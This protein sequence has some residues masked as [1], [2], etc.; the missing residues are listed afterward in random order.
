M[1]ERS[2][3]GAVRETD[4]AIE[5]IEVHERP[6]SR[7]AFKQAFEV[8]LAY[9]RL[10]SGAT[11]EVMKR[12]I[13]DPS[14]NQLPDGLD[15]GRGQ[16]P[17]SLSSRLT[18]GL[19]SLVS[20]VGLRSGAMANHISEFPG[21]FSFRVPD[22]TSLRA[23]LASL[24]EQKEGERLERDLVKNFLTST[25]PTFHR[26]GLMLADDPFRYADLLDEFVSRSTNED[27]LALARARLAERRR[28]QMWT[29]FYR[30]N[31]G[32]AD[33]HVAEERQG[34]QSA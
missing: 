25:D 9:N 16:L 29:S 30:S 13:E 11:M 26:L 1:S 21:G 3:Q 28:L 6:P 24:C 31:E 34:S 23:F 33:S 2:L 22:V 5:E 17:S 10:R 8:V 7:H 19:Q 12:N 18:K 32:E 15:R 4:T 27:D 20:E 14:R